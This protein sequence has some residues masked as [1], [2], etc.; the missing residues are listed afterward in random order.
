MGL[1]KV[2]VAALLKYFEEESLRVEKVQ[3]YTNARAATSTLFK[4]MFGIAT[5]PRVCWDRTCSM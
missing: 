1:N 2:D 4:P 5:F 3:E